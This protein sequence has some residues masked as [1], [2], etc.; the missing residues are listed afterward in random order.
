MNSSRGTILRVVLVLLVSLGLLG[1]LIYYSVQ[2]FDRFTTLV[3]KLNQQRNWQAR[4]ANDIVIDISELDRLART[5]QLTLS[6]SDLTP[7]LQKVDELSHSI[8]TLY[9][10]S[11][12]TEYHD[13]VDTLSQVFAEKVSNFE[14]L[15]QFKISQSS[16]QDDI[17]ALEL[18]ADSR[19]EILTDSMLIPTR[20][21]TTT[22]VTT[23]NQDSIEK[24]GLISR[25]FGGKEKEVPQREM[26]Q[27]RTVAYDSAY[28]EKV[29]TMMA[30]VETALRAAE[31][32]R[33]YEQRLLANRELQ[34][35]S[36]DLRIIDKLKSIAAEIERLNE[37]MLHE[38]RIKAVN[39]AE[40]ALNQVLFWVICGGVL[41][42]LFTV[43]VVRDIF[44]SV[45]LQRELEVSKLKAEK[46]ASSREEFLA[47]MSHELRTPLNSI[48]GFTGQIYD[49]VPRAGDKIDRLRKS[50]EHV[51][52]IVNDILDY[53]RIE[54]GKLPIERTGFKPRQ[55]L[56]ECLEMISFQAETKDLEIACDL[57]ENTEDLIVEG[58]PLRLK[59]ILI[60]LTNNAI[61]FTSQGRVGL[62]LRAEDVG[63]G[64]VTLHFAVMDTGKGIS[65]DRLERIFESFDQ[66]DASIN[67][68]YGGTGLGL[69][70]S[71]KL[72]HLQGGK[73]EVE[74][75]PGKG[76]RFSFWLK[77]PR[78]ESD[79]YGTKSQPESAELDL[80][81]RSLLLV[82]DDEMNHILLKPVFKKWG[83]DLKAPLPLQ[84]L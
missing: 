38:Q 79:E 56:Q 14:A 65:P 69:S 46:L 73:L 67:R 33:R 48:I 64:E 27:E 3:D 20:E 36:N 44:E 59:Q 1:T 53:S 50:S 35:A 71:R 66:E 22:T 84:R 75:T 62:E 19:D 39:Q 17:S 81:G 24:K 80:S 74:S 70:I 9:Q 34:I 57:A 13:E 47:N 26:M 23:S 8:D 40:A 31:S 16:L 15:I 54:S 55:I 6:S 72:I 68:K 32:Q 41:T 61:K 7:Y 45:R 58:D 12:G 11:F 37:E 51:L 43:W 52:R 60:N 77:Y 29:D 28:F 63:K 82:D 83:L 76:S 2:S 18:L 5:Y 10:G 25:I 42:I 30:S 4:V 49:E 78:A 21:V